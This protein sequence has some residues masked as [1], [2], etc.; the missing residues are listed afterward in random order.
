MIYLL[1]SFTEAVKAV[2]PFLKRMLEDDQEHYLDDYVA[3]TRK[4]GLQENPEDNEED[5][6]VRVD[7]TLLVVYARK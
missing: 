1:F 4:L 3:Y 2:N 7:Y 5:I 6:R